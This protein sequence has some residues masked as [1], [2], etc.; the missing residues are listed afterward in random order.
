[1]A[2]SGNVQQTLQN[3]LK[4][5]A[6]TQYVIIA[7]LPTTQHI[8]SDVTNFYRITTGSQK[9]KQRIICQFKSP[10]NISHPKSP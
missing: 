5:S 4:K 10:R 3:A 8:C 7:S 2:F 1:M 6:I 9:E